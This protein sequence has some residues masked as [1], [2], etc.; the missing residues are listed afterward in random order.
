MVSIESQL[1]NILNSDKGEREIHKFLKSHM[2]LL[3]MAFNPAWNYYR[4]FSEFRL[5]DDFRA[6]F[7]ILSA[8]SLN[9]HAIFIELKNFNVRLYTKDGTPAKPF[10]LAQKQINEWR[11]WKRMNEAYLRRK[12]SDLL[13]KEDAPAIFYSDDTDGYKSGA[14][15]IADM[16]SRIKYSYHIVIGRSSTLSAEEREFRQRDLSWGGAEVATYDRFLTMAKRVDET[17]KLL[18]CQSKSIK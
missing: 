15:E 7:L 3:I 10:R 9:W 11:N 13:R 18:N 14:A 16:K 5:G 4:C 17:N 8:H 12:F 1:S 6:D 2:D